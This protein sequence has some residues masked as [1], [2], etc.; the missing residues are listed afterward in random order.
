MKRIRRMARAIKLILVIGLS[1]TL[2]HSSLSDSID[3]KHQ[4]GKTT[5]EIHNVF[6]DLNGVLLSVSKGKMFRQLG[7]LPFLRY[8]LTFN[9]LKNL[10]RTF[11]NLKN[12]KKKLYSIAHA[13]K[14]LNP[15]FP[16]AYDPYGNRLPQLFM[17]WQTGLYS[18]ELIRDALTAGIDGNPHLFA[19]ST[20]QNLIRAIAHA[21]FTPEILASAI[22]PIAPGVQLVKWC[23]QQGMRVFVLSNF[24]PQTFK[25]IRQN[26]P[27][28]FELFDQ[29]CI[30]ISGNH[31]LMKPDDRFYERL[32]QQH[33]LD[34]ATC[35]FFDDQQENIAAAQAC[36][37]NGIIVGKKKK[38]FRSHPD[39]ATAQKT[40]EDL[41][42]SDTT[43]GM[44]SA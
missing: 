13:I 42:A 38:L 21:I 20:E 43:G 10:K 12:L 44:I 32:L 26:N 35:V 23:K 41:V 17:D 11:N 4:S 39:I 30:F 14:P 36:G 29:E 33:D 7:I 16:E 5:A 15:D 37:I 8:F 28:L 25:I 22:R 18:S 1:C 6:F 2:V 31:G 3:H 34:P 9:N 27:E 24:D 40:F 19:N